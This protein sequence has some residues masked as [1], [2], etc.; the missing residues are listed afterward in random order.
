MVLASS[1]RIISTD[2]FLGGTGGGALLGG[3]TG[4]SNDAVL[5]DGSGGAQ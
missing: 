4:S 1:A 2:F 5:P 3:S